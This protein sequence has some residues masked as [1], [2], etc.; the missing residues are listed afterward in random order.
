L[1]N[2]ADACSIVTIALSLYGSYL[3]QFNFRVLYD[4]GALVAE[5]RHGISSNLLFGFM[6]TVLAYSSVVVVAIA[7]FAY[8]FGSGRTF[9]EY[10]QRYA[11]EVNGC[12]R[13]PYLFPT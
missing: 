11:D 3:I 12:V 9:G 7:S 6:M 4:R 8:Y 1:D 13:W 2:F 5:F 10:V